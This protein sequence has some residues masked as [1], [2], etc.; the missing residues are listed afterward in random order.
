MWCKDARGFGRQDT[1]HR[2]L[3]PPKSDLTQKTKTVE[4]GKR[5]DGLN[6]W[7][8]FVYL[9]EAGKYLTAFGKRVTTEV[10]ILRT[11]RWYRSEI[12]MCTLNSMAT[13]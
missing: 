11:W 1:V 10:I 5:C 8:Q 2:Y 9:F 13:S 3:Y 4:I 7:S 6:G 12:S